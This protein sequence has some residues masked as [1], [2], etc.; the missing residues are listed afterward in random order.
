MSTFSDP[1]SLLGFLPLILLFSASFPAQ[2]GRYSTLVTAFMTRRSTSPPRSTTP[3]PLYNRLSA[4]FTTLLPPLEIPPSAYA[5]HPTPSSSR[6]LLH[7]FLPPWPSLL[8]Q[9]PPREV[10]DLPPLRQVKGP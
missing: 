10:L 6:F 7:H 4:R 5:S 3:H 1:F 9:S 8:L 2:V